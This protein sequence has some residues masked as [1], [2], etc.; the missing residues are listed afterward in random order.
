MQENNTEEFDVVV[1]GGGPG[2][3]SLA[4]L[5]AMQGHRVLLLEK[6]TFPRYQIGE[7]LLPATTQWICGLLGVTKELESA[8]FQTKTGGTF[9][10]GASP[11]PWSFTF[12]TVSHGERFAYQVE[13]MKFDQILLDRAREIG[14]DVREQCAVK[15][16]IADTER[17]RGVR[18]VDADGQERQARATFVVDA[19]GER[20][21]I[22]RGAG[23]SRRFS[24]F[25]KNIALFGY[26]EG[27]KRMPAPR[28]GNITCV[29]FSGGW[30]WYIPLTNELT[31]VGAVVPAE[32]ADKVRGDREQ[33]L[34]SLIGECPMISD[35][36]SDARRVTE[37]PYG[38]IRVRK[39]YSYCDTRFW[40]PGIT[41]I[42]DAACF[43]DPLFSTGVYLATYSALLAARS[44]N[45]VLDG[46]VDE[47]SAFAESEFRHR[48][49]YGLYYEFLQSIYDTHVDESSY[50]W[51]AKKITNN[52]LSE[53]D[54]FSIL[55][56]GMAAGEYNL[57]GAQPAADGGSA[58]AAGGAPHTAPVSPDEDASLNAFWKGRAMVRLEG[59][60]QQRILA[61][62]EEGWKDRPER[63][64][65]SADNL[66]W[67]VPA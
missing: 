27:G 8:G 16:V 24:E 37:G 60:N 31:S 39:D 15:E 35:F 28:S 2:G 48:R 57:P 21:R 55:T 53:R 12:S 32:M 62:I 10:W 44:I 66:H 26:F 13:R 25:F 61:S 52:S 5:V 34:L 54:S 29:A 45:S 20:S 23:G 42:G 11:E 67:E 1:V 36:L 50:F 58:Q 4:T 40:S 43:V 64:V 7:S 46:R 9:L 30:F 38:E 3:S 56:A 59:T 18:Y 19:S 47:Q 41:L 17:V 33:S 63:L 22:H 51:T 49:E 14:V 65:V 6:E